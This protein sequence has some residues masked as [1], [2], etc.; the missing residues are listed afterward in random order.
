MVC[1]GQWDVGRSD[2]VQVPSW[3]LKWVSSSSLVASALHYKNMSHSE[4][5][6]REEIW[7]NPKHGSSLVCGAL[8]SLVENSQTKVGP[9]VWNECLVWDYLLHSIITVKPDSC[10]WNDSNIFK[11]HQPLLQ[12]LWFSRVTLSYLESCSACS[13]LSSVAFPHLSTSMTIH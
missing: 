8:L 5:R 7:N 3:D 2:I 10:H 6:H 4:G 13:L 9:W 1:F 11:P 12:P